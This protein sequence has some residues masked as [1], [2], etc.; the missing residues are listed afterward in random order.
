VI[1]IHFEVESRGE[2]SSED[3]VLTFS[4]NGVFDGIDAGVFSEDG[5][6]FNLT[7]S[8]PGCPGDVTYIHGIRN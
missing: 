6:S 1:A 5:S 3:N 2:T 4:S 7:N 8:T